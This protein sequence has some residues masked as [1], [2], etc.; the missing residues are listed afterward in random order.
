MKPEYETRTVP[1][2]LRA[3]SD[4]E[5][6]RSIE[7]Q[8]IV[9]DVWSDDLG[10]FRERLAV[11]SAQLD[12][13]LLALW[14]HQTSMVLGRTT[15]GTLRAHDDGSGVSMRAYPPD[16]TWARDLLVSMDRG[17][18]RHMSFRFRTI[19]DTWAIGADGVPER[20]VLKMSVPEISVVSM[21]AY[22][23]TSSYA[24]SKAE[25]VRSSAAHREDNGDEGG[26][27]G[28][29]C[30]EGG[31][32]DRQGRLYLFAGQGVTFPTPERGL[33]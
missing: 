33:V 11:G 3:V 12:A 5:R 1:V 23:Q 19:D 4:D 22:P 21:P 27:P 28:D 29:P 17:D 13:D 10:G 15:A 25:E 30:T 9:Y 14:D 18:V 8:A 16:T 6:G 2:T 26:S 24:R 32:P 20:T 31:S 7:G